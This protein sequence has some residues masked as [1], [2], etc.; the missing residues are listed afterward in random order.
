MHSETPRRA[1]RLTVAGAH[2]AACLAPRLRPGLAS[3]SL[4]LAR[5]PR[6]AAQ[7]LPPYTLRSIYL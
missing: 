5:F 6:G 1:R 4:R 7:L 3:P 2:T